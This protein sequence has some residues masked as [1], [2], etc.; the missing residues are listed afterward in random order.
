MRNYV[1]YEIKGMTGTQK[2]QRG[3]TIFAFEDGV[4]LVDPNDQTALE[5]IQELGGVEKKKPAKKASK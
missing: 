2:I 3:S 1:E 5:M 4:C